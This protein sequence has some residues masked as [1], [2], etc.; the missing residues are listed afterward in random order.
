MNNT[1]RGYQMQLEQIL[2]RFSEGLVVV[3]REFNFINSSRN[4]IKYLPGLST[5]YEP[6]C[7]EEVMTWWKNTYPKDFHNL[8]NISTNYP[9]PEARANKCDIIFS[10]DDQELDNA[11]WAIE[12]KKIAF[13]GD[14]GKNNDYGPSKLLSPF[15]KDRSLS[16]DIIK[17]NE[18]KL[19]RHKAVIGYGFDY[20]IS[21]LDVA[22]SKFPHEVDRIKNA[23]KT[24]KSAGMPGDKLEMKPLLDIA[25]FIMEKLDLT[26]PLVTREFKDA[27]HHPLGGNGTVFAWELK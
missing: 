1:A 8:K 3:D 10:S 16:H 4:G 18:S 6:Q 14:N 22:L 17:L 9:Y 23:K 21:S 12:L 19:A 25:D 5:I 7:A 24:V 26:K 2:D 20:T 27:W 11:E 13:L 15:L